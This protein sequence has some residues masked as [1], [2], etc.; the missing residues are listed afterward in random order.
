MFDVRKAIDDAIKVLEE[1]PCQTLVIEKVTHGL[2]LAWDES[3]ELEPAGSVELPLRRAARKVLYEC[4]YIV[5]DIV[6]SPYKQDAVDSLAA[7]RAALGMPPSD[8][9]FFA[10]NDVSYLMGLIV[11]YGGQ[12]F[13]QGQQLQERK[14][15]GQWPKSDDYTN[16]RKEAILQ[17]IRLFLH[18][19]VGTK[20]EKR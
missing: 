14:D 16:K 1:L 19:A 6:E 12:C 2:R 20:G 3:A 13:K 10:K 5:P 15:R 8:K 9:E 11:E 7:L 4:E 18:G 17:D